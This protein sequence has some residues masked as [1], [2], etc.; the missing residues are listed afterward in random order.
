METDQTEAIGDL[1]WEDRRLCPDGSC[2][3]TLN[4]DG[5]CK[6]CKTDWEGHALSGNDG[7]AVAENDQTPPSGGEAL[8]AAPSGDGA[9]N[10]THQTK[11]GAVENGAVEDGDIDAEWENRRLC[12][13]GHCIGVIGEDDHCR[14][15][16]KPCE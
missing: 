4:K 6:K 14:E 9:I 5:H 8:D 7:A 15:C 10:E 2:I 1:E 3:G 16:G 11:S 13:D 12:L